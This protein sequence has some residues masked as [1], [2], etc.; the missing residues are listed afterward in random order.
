LLAEWR[1]LCPKPVR[2]VA[3]NLFADLFLADESRKIVGVDV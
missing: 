3:H 2:L 1:W